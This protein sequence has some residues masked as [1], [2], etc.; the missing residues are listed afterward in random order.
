M[1]NYSSYLI[2]KLALFTKEDIIISN[3][4]MIRIKQRQLSIDEIKENIINPKRLKYAIKQTTKKEREEKFD[5]YFD[6]SKNLCHRYVL[7]IKNN[8]IVVTA[9]KINKK[10]QNIIYKKIKG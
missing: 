2:K 7:V 8:I 10:W 9:I 3:H 6:Y 5:C 4:A 1:K